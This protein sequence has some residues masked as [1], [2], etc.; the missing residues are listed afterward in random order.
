MSVVSLDPLGLSWINIHNLKWSCWLPSGWI[1]SIQNRVY[2]KKINNFAHGCRTSKTGTRGSSGMCA[3]R[4]QLCDDSVFHQMRPSPAKQKYALARGALSRETNYAAY[5]SAAASGHYRVPTISSLVSYKVWRYLFPSER[6]QLKQTENDPIDD[7]LRGRHALA[8][9][10]AGIWA[11]GL[12]EI[13][14][15]TTRNFPIALSALPGKLCHRLR[16][17]IAILNKWHL[18]VFR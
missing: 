7:A 11:F 10:P 16:A 5:A 3:L 12:F 9:L 13:W 15:K 8:S 14:I 4:H 18:H 1:L 2:R 6:V 17:F